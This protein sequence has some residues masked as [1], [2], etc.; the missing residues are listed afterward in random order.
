[1]ACRKDLRLRNKKVAEKRKTTAKMGV[2]VKR[3]LIIAEE[4]GK[5]REHPNNGEHWKT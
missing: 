4:Q 3:D 2:G 5:W 1:M